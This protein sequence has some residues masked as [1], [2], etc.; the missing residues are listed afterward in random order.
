[1]LHLLIQPFKQIWCFQGRSTRKEYW[2]FSIFWGIFFGLVLELGA[3]FVTNTAADLGINS[4]FNLE[5]GFTFLL[6][7]T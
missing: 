7:H 4:I 5:R 1:M 6:S 2:V 3:D